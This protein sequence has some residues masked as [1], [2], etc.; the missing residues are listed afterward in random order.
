[1]REFIRKLLSYRGLAACTVLLTLALAALLARSIRVQFQFRDFYDFP[2]NA[3]AAQ[4]RK[5]IDRFGDPAGF[6]VA[7]LE[8]ERVFRA[9]NLAYVRSLTRALEPDPVFVRVISLSNVHAIRGAG[10]DVVSGPLLAE[11]PQSATELAELERFALASPLLRRKLVS[12]DGKLTAVLAEMRTPSAYATIAEQERAV[13]VVQRAVASIPMPAGVKVRVTG[14]PV[15]DTGVTRALVRDQMVLVPAVVAALSVV[16]FIAFRSLWCLLVSLSTVGVAALWT[17]GAFALLG[18][19]VDIIGSMVP[20]SILVYGMVDPIFVIARVLH[21]QHAGLEKLEAISEASSELG[22][23]CFLTSLTTALGF[24][25]F[26]SAHQPTVRYYGLTVA[27]GVL[28]SWVT[29]VTVLPILLSWV[30][31]PA[32]GFSAPGSS[33]WLETALRS[34]WHFLRR[35]VRSTL[36]VTA[37]LL[38]TG[39]LFASRQRI[40]NQYVGELPRGDTQNDVHRFEHTLAGIVSMTVH[41]EGPRD[42]FKQPAVL[43]RIARVDQMM[44]NQALVTGVSSLAELVAEANQAF[45]G[46]QLDERRVPSSRPLIAQYL[47]LIDPGD[48]ASFVTDD[49]S[50]AQIAIALVDPGS[51]RTRVIAAALGDSVKQVDFGALGI[52]AV[53]SGKGLVSYDELDEVVVGLLYGFALAFAAIVLLQWL[54]FRSLRIALISV[55]PNSLPVVA[56]FVCLRA[57]GVHLRIDTAL[58]LCIS[59]GGLFNTT[60][61]F[62]ARVRQLAGGHG[63]RPEPETVIESAMLSI[64]PPA[65]FTACA[66]SVGFS[67]L[68]A[69]S[70]AGLQ[71]LGLLTMVTLSVGFFADMTVTAVLLRAGLD[72][73]AAAT[74]APS[75]AMAQRL[76]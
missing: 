26:L 5:D 17:A 71:A 44:A 64:G 68:F 50:Q 39:A 41:L 53:V 14:A 70:F 8:T 52:Q 57:F 61:H 7:L 60:I 45:H 27:I 38:V 16:V 69:S 40:D 54:V 10:D 62:A 18:R 28:L 42:A 2:G 35:R 1:V 72:W 73:R 43:K 63:A 3:R 13:A 6:V 20:I 74:A 46:G 33:G 32:R 65:L 12:S 59:V 15:V 58:V 51:E 31:L 48:R 47:A 75:R 4:L 55:V 34:T 24:A 21:K 29:S 66:L 9:D 19:P 36:L 22:L 67:V 11:M 49:Y 23:P 30:P 37:V 76:V 25:A 56:C